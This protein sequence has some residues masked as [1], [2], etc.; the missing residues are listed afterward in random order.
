MVD[1]T[2][3]DKFYRDFELAQTPEEKSKLI[4]LFTSENEISDEDLC[5]LKA[6]I[7]DMIENESIEQ[8]SIINF[9]IEDGIYKLHT[10]IEPIDQYKFGCNYYIKTYDARDLYQSSG[11]GDNDPL[12]SEMINS[13]KPV[14]WIITDDGI[15]TLK[16]KNILSKD[17]DFQ[18]YF[19]KFA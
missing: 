5:E 2:N 4:E 17:I 9:E 12:I 18:K 11:I 10:C 13:I 3:F 14:Y 1:L 15:G 7:N 6:Q 16:R 8:D 19:T